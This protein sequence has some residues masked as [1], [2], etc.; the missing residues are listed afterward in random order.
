MSW[1][2]QYK[3]SLPEGVSGDWSIARFTVTPEAEKF[4]QLRA[5][6][7]TGSRGRYVPQGTYTGLYRHGEVIM[8]D[9][10][11]EIRDHYD[12]IQRARGNCLISG[13]GL[14]VVADAFLRK[15]EVTHVTVI[16]LSPDVI[17]LVAAPLLAKYGDRLTIVQ[18]DAYTWTPPKGEVYDVVWHDIWD[19]LCSDNLKEMERLH[20]KYG[21]KASWQGSWGKEQCQYMRRR[22]GCW[23]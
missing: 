22:G 16:E 14:G 8:S 20:R 17:K 3:V 12:P 10:P 21:R 7:S 11:D 9:T 23:G 5:M 6:I 4:G 2:E 13:L 15:P 18:A 1:W 19:N